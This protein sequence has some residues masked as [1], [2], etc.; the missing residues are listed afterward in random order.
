VSLPGSRIRPLDRRQ[1]PPRKVAWL[2]PSQLLRTAYHVWLSSTAS[3]FLDRREVLAAL[4]PDKEVH[5]LRPRRNGDGVW[6]DFVADIGDSWEATHAVASLLAEK[7]LQVEGHGKLL[8]YADILVLGGDLVYPTPT[9]TRYRDRMRVPLGAALPQA[10]CVFERDLYAIPG[11]HDWYDGL[12]NFVREF[13]QRGYLGGWQLHQRRS[14]FAVKL[15]PHWWLWGID[16]ALDTRI[17]P[18]QQSYFLDILQNKNGQAP[19]HQP[20]DRGDNI[21]LCTA[22]PSWLHGSRYSDDACHNLAYFVKE[23]IE[24]HNGRVP[25]LLAGDLHHYS[26]YESPRGEQMIIAGGGGAYLMGTHNLPREVPP[27]QSPP[28]LLDDPRDTAMC[29]AAEF[30]YPSHADSRRLALRALRL[31]FR[32][33]NWVFCLIV[34]MIYLLL[35]RFGPSIPELTWQTLRTLLTAPPPRPFVWLASSVLVVSAVFCVIANPNKRFVLTAAWG[36]AHGLAHVVLALVLSWLVAGQHWLDVSG[37]MRLLA[38][39]GVL[40]LGGLAGGTLIGLYLIVSDRFLGWHHNEVFA[41]TSIIDYRNFVRLHLAPD[42][43]HVDLYAIG[44]RRVPRKW[45]SRIDRL[46][47]SDGYYEPVDDTLRPHLIEGPI[48]VPPIR[49]P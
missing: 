16:I 27:L 33:A 19:N 9:R 13:C 22:K 31:A 46:S 6:V 24:P 12:T 38:A 39:A 20:F 43:S 3:E 35:M 45:R 2:L 1:L 32:P 23:V 44:M 8:R 4:D 18:A 47:Q 29:R 48:T 21:I 42:G 26:R 49:V 7:E 37:P 5:A 30:P 15:M 41:V 34:G 10:D 17:D 40:V 28:P 36:I 11:N 14:Y 25:L